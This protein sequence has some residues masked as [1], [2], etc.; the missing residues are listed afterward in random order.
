[1]G[2]I[3]PDGASIFTMVE[4]PDIKVTDPRSREKSAEHPVA[5]LDSPSTADGSQPPRP[6]SSS[7][8]GMSCCIPKLPSTSMYWRHGGDMLAATYASCIYISLGLLVLTAASLAGKG[9]RGVT[10]LPVKLIR[11]PPSKT[12]NVSKSSSPPPVER[13]STAI[14]PLSHVRIR[15][16]EPKIS[17]SIGH[18]D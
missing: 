8:E 15:D 2:D 13:P 9:Q 5:D 18:I 3:L 11:N 16:S 17:N 1:M 6:K 12:G 14:D 7:S 4:L 10:K